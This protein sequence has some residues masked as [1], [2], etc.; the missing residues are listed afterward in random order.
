MNIE[1]LIK[2][3]GIKVKD[4]YNSSL[5]HGSFIALCSDLKKRTEDYIP[6]ISIYKYLTKEER[7]CVLS[8]EFGH[9]VHFYKTK[10]SWPE[11]IRV[12]YSSKRDRLKVE[13]FCWEYAEREFN[14]NEEYGCF[15]ILMENSLKGYRGEI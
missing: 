14:Y 2:D 8:H 13:E 7:E 5:G 1:E 15:N 4:I 11:Y 3:N 9:F 10:L 6:I 12:H